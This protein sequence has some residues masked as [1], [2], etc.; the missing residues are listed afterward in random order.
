M[1]VCVCVYVC[2]YVCTC[3]Y[4]Y[5]CVC[6][7]ACVRVCASVCACVHTCMCMCVCMCVCSRETITNK[8]LRIII[9]DFIVRNYRKQITLFVL[10][11]II[12][13]ESYRISMSN[14]CSKPKL[15]FILRWFISVWL[16]ND[17]RVLSI[18]VSNLAF[19]RLGNKKCMY[20]F[21]FQYVC[22]HILQTG[23][24]SIF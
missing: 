2:V 7:C 11:H 20:K 10:P 12:V 1:C 4:V 21:S 8:T 19:K 5:V 13:V 16:I 3:V 22:G 15:V 9:N 24:R 6:M 17:S 14:I 18:N 23:F